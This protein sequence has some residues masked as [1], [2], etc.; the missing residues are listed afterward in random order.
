MYRVVF[1]KCIVLRITHQSIVGLEDMA[2]AKAKFGF[3]DT[4]EWK[5]I[6]NYEG[7]FETPI[8]LTN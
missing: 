6:C 8:A 3:T 1:C 5:F 4:D 2:A 7:D